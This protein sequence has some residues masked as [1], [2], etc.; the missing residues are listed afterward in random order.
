M[1]ITLMEK[2]YKD[3]QVVLY[4]NGFVGAVSDRSMI[5]SAIEVMNAIGYNIIDVNHILS[6]N[7][8][9]PNNEAD[10]W[11]EGPK[12]APVHLVETSWTHHC[13]KTCCFDTG[14][15]INVN[16]KDVVTQ[17]SVVIELLQILEKLGH[18]V[19]MEKTADNVDSKP[20]TIKGYCLPDPI[21][22]IHLEMMR[23]THNELME[24]NLVH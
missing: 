16:G 17:D 19:S 3:N 18:P 2:V 13:Y 6:L 7:D 4:V 23:E 11:H 20:G 10:Y 14:Y 24:L 9:V 22:E 21:E 15:K 1:N 8:D 12:K 5:N